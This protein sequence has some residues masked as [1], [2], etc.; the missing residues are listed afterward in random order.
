MDRG[1]EPLHAPQ[2]PADQA[3]A[4]S[5]TRHVAQDQPDLDAPR[6]AAID[7]Q[8]DA[9]DRQRRLRAGPVARAQ[10]AVGTFLFCHKGSHTTETRRHRGK[11]K[12]LL[13]VSVPLW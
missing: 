6:A 3:P 8:I 2:P 5:L 7:E 10:P 1:F 4:A 9:G 11:P 13:C 12:N